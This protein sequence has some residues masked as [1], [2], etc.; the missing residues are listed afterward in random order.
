MNAPTLECG[1]L[2]GDAQRIRDLVSATGF[3]NAEEI[4]ISAELADDWLRLKDQS[5]YRF[6][7]ARQ[8]TNVMGYTCFGRIPGSSH[9]WDLYWVAVSPA[10]QGAGL[11]RALLR[12]TEQVIGDA[13]GQRIYVDT[14][15]RSQY[16]TTRAYYERCGYTVAAV[17]ADFYAP[18]DGK[19]I[20]L[21]VLAAGT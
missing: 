1:L 6:V 9:S 7:T 13:G 21:K 4:A 3:F 18:G 16:T 12:R 19:V 2:P 17:L 15:S 14:S 5:D 11:G 10:H 8:G 20:Y